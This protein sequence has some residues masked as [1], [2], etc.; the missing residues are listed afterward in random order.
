MLA[1]LLAS[2]SWCS[3]AAAPTPLPAVSAAAADERPLR[4]LDAWLK[5]YFAGKI[6][7]RSK[8]NIAKDSIAAKFGLLPKN[9]LGDP[10]WAGDL[11]AILAAVARLETPA[12]A[13]A[14]LEVAAVGIDQGK[15]TYEMAAYDVRVAGETWAAKL[16]TP[17]AR[18]QLALAAR[19]EAKTDKNKAV[20]IQ[21]AGVRCVGLLKDPALRP[22]LEQALG[23]GDDL[24]RIH[25]A[26]ALGALGDEEAALPLIGVLQRDTVDSVLVSAAQ[27][28]RSLYARHLPQ[29][30]VFEPGKDGS[31]TAG[32]DAV[33]P[34][35]PAQPAPPAELP[36]S[37]RLAVRA[38]IGAL[39]RTS[40]RADMALVRLLDDFRSLETVPALIGVLERFQARPEDLKSGKS[41][42]LL[43]YQAHE[44]LVAMTGAVYPAD[45]PAKW[46]TFWDTEKDKI[47]VTQKREPKGT[48]TTV[49]SGFC[50][51]PVQGTRVVFILDLSGSM[52]WPM[53]EV[54]A[55]GKKKRSIRLD[56]AKRELHRAMDA[57][58]PNA[59]FNLVTFN[60][61]D[62]AESW[63]KDLVVATDK[64]RERFKKY[65]DGLKARGGTN[66]WSGLE[67]ALKIKSLVYG[68]RYATT[69]DE[70]F[71]LSDGAPTVGDVTDPVEIL[72]LVQECNKFSQARI[73][74]VYIS[75]A[76]P[77]EFRQAEPRMAI[78][79]QEL[80]RRMAEQNG[81][82]F[83][84]L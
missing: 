83:R 5:L 41:S 9:G 10:T 71:I 35:E 30:G 7:F 77:E 76:T 69:V 58:A 68:N 64:N 28:L 62:K 51:I 13:Q 25:A 52:D 72:R 53:E 55:D 37:V 60:G 82:K 54:G 29:P 38:A 73:N 2:M 19:G 84:E 59:M 26:E 65:V 40:W 3:P 56:F 22:V 8:T 34:A 24:V 14:L 4:A 33:K 81:G 12:A 23:D 80:M 21:V 31:K 57:I 1:L 17:E 63:S 18:A 67:D 78:T 42:G 50:G 32:G 47:V 16:Q 27:A 45:Q 15:Y 48:P 79:P 36:E 20:A 75:S 61:D 66:L 43:L 11:D 44:L 74:T 70:V 49:A 39:G 46:R 6:D